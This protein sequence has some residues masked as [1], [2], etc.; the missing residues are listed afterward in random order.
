M[1]VLEIA[2]V[3]DVDELVSTQVRAFID[4]NKNKPAGYSLEGP[5]GYDSLDWNSHWIQ[6]THYYKILSS[7]H[8]VGGLILFDMGRNQMEV[9]RI[10]IDPVHQNQKIGLT[11]MNTMFALHPDV[12]LWTLGTPSWAERNQHFYEKLGFIKIRETDVDPH[13]GW[14]GVE[15]EYHLE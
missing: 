1:I 11:A 12:C 2:S 15:Y 5:P 13:L 3:D 10:W 6:N 9:G 8:I 7:G 14:S 4:D